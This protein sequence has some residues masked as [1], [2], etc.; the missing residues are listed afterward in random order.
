[1]GNVARIG[2]SDW[3]NGSVWKSGN[4]RTLFPEKFGEGGAIRRLM[5]S[6][7][8]L[9]DGGRRR[10]FSPSLDAFSDVLLTASG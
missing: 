8:V 3:Q 5:L 2:P 9:G 1:M 6:T 10:L 7:I 4:V